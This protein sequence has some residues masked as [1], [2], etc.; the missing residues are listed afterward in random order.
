M[1]RRSKLSLLMVPALL[2]LLLLINEVAF[3]FPLTPLWLDTA[4]AARFPAT[5]GRVRVLLVGDVLLADAARGIIAERGHGYPFGAT[6]QLMQ[7]ADLAVGNLEGPISHSGSVDSGMLWSYR[8]APAAAAA[9]GRA[10]FS[11]MNLANNHMRDCGEVGVSETI[12]HLR[13]AGVIPFGAGASEQQAHA[14][15]VRTVRGVTIG[16]LGYMAPYMMLG[17]QKQSMEYHCWGKDQGGAARGTA[18]LVARDV[19]RLRPRADLVVVSFHM[20]DRYQR[21]PTDWERKLC[22]QAIDAGADAV[23][24]HGPHILGPVELYRGRPILYSVGNFA[25]GSGNIFARFSLAALL[26]I[27]P[28]QKRLRGVQLLPLYT[29]NHNPWVRFQTKILSGLQARRVLANL[30]DISAPYH[31]TLVQRTDPLRGW[32]Q[33]GGDQ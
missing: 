20:G 14:P 1:K 21:R 4:G 5:P 30:A 9:L 29:V 7:G 11:L 33:L 24:N 6:R 23:V 27:D 31:A 16:F 10:G 28:G 2:A 17:G 18:A 22:Q 19:R 8:M 13:R 26:E 12:S 15:A 3:V 25:F 32:L